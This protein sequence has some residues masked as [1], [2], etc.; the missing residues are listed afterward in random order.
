MGWSMAELIDSIK[1]KEKVI[2]DLQQKKARQEGQLAQL[3]QQ[4]KTEYDVNTLEEAA[5]LLETLQ[6]EKEENDGKLA[7]IDTNM[8]NIIA[9]AQ[10][11][12]SEPSASQSGTK[13]QGRA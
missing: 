2:R 5:S 13:I 10:G 4:L 9:T 11:Q 3:F 1:Q 7:E 12:R 6:S 8:G